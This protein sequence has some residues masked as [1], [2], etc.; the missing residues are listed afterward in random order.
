MKKLLFV[1][2]LLFVPVSVEAASSYAVVDA[3]TGRVLMGE[4]ENERY[5]IASLTKMWTALVAI[6]EGHLEDMVTVSK[7]AVYS[8]GSSIYL[9]EGQQIPL[10]E[11]LY[12]LMLRSGN[13]AATAIAE[14][15]GG[16]VEGFVKL[17]N[18]KAVLHGLSGTVFTNPSGLHHEEHLAT[19][20]DT[21]RMLQIAMKNETFRK[22]ASTVIYKGS[23]TTWQNKHKLLSQN[24]GAVAGKTGYTKVAGRTLATYFERGDKAFVVV[25][26]NESNDWETHKFIA[27]AID[28]RYES[29]T[30]VEKGEYLIPNATITIEKPITLLLT[31]QE[32]GHIEHMLIAQ[33]DYKRAIWH[34]KLNND[35]LFS[36][37]VSIKEDKG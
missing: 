34:V 6:E 21:A 14:H 36:T 8:E 4:A 23:K 29:Y 13:D 32:R 11:L 26:I 28:Q 37:R 15:V 27:D 20:A 30:L 33:R 22:I 19:A 9:E 2:F 18:D 12:G 3:E 17:M 10:E 1:L 24:V 35:I 16:S 25:T 31:A 7:R 5:P